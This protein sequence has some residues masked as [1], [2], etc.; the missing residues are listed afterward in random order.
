[1][2][3]KFDITGD[4][5]LLNPQIGLISPFN[6]LK[7]KENSSPIMWAICMIE[8][9]NSYNKLFVYKRAERLKWVCE[10]YLNINEKEFIELYG[11][12]LNEYKNIVLTSKEE[13][14]YYEWAKKLEERDLFLH[15]TP[16]NEDT[17]EMLDKMIANH[18]KIWK[19][20]REAGKS[21]FAKE[22]LV[23]TRGNI[24]ES[25]SSQGLI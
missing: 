25:E 14:E 8:D 13:I 18:D 1:M 19:I 2:L 10:N 15:N 5:W 20:F 9:S 4:F 17:F 3:D 12:Y 21:L 16:Y 7:E 11:K 24:V 22:E 23:K 6:E